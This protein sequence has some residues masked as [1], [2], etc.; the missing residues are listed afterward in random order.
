MCGGGD[1]WLQDLKLPLGS[2]GGGCGG[3]CNG[4]GGPQVIV[5]VRNTNWISGGGGGGAGGSGGLSCPYQYG[6]GGYGVQLPSTFR[7]PDSIPTPGLGCT[8]DSISGPGP[9]SSGPNPGLFWVGG[10]GGGDETNP[11]PQYYGVVVE[12]VIKLQNHHFLQ[13]LSMRK[14][15]RQEPIGEDVL[16]HWIRWYT[17][18]TVEVM[19]VLDLFSSYILPLDK[20]QGLI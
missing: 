17:I 11:Q 18:I 14:W 7:N 10:G 6:R 19:V 9:K 1:L 16:Q 12:E 20:F 8:M 2:G 13:M 4:P 3:G 15:R 5:V